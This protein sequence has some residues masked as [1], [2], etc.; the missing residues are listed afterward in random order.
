MTLKVTSFALVEDKQYVPLPEQTG[1]SSISEKLRGASSNRRRR[2]YLAAGSQELIT[3]WCVRD[4]VL[5]KS[6]VG[7]KSWV[8]CLQVSERVSL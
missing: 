6:L 4:F 5:L 3:V 2:F 7:H 8:F 1:G